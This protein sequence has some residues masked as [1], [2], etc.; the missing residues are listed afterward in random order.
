SGAKDTVLGDTKTASD[1]TYVIY[2]LPKHEGY[3]Q[4]FAS[5]NC[6]TNSEKVLTTQTGS[7]LTGINTSFEA[8]EPDPDPDPD[9]GQPDIVQ[10]LKVTANGSTTDDATISWDAFPYAKKYR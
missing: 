9:P 7:D 2:G 1:G 3:W 5:T 4:R 6:G 8:S 10:R